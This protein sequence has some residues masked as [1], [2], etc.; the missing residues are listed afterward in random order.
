M[1][2]MLCMDLRRLFRTRS[3]YII[4]GVTAALLLAVVLLAAAISSPDTLDAIQS[5]GAEIDEY[6]RQMAEGIRS[7]TQLEFIAECIGGGSL[8]VMA[9]LGMTLFVHGDFSSGYIKNIRFVRPRRWEYV[10]SKILLAGVYSGVLTALGILVSLTA[11]LL[12]GLHPP[13]SPM[14]R[15]LEYALWSWLL[16]WAFSLM[17]LSLAALTRSSVPG[18]VL[19]VLA[20]GGLTTQLLA[21]ACR[22]LHWPDL[23]QYLLSAV[24]SS[25][26]VPMPDAGQITMILGCSIGWAAVYSL[27]SLAALERRDI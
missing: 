18:L 1:F 12:F 4:L 2:N 24:V 27:G 14:V 26:C 23:W 15:I 21:L 13:A 9:G 25:Q 7:M 11:P 16:Y 6:D 20:G 5:Q 10:L 22:A 8:L 3:F 19:T 17:G